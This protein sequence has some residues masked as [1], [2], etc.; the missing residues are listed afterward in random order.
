MSDNEGGTLEEGDYPTSD[1]SEDE[2]AS[3]EEEEV[4]EEEASSEED[5]ASEED[6]S[7]HDNIVNLLGKEDEKVKT[8]TYGMTRGI[9]S[10]F[11]YAG[12]LKVR[13]E[14]L[15]DQLRRG[16]K[17]DIPGY[18]GKMDVKEIAKFEI[19]NGLFE[20]NVEKEL[21]NGKYE[22]VSSKNLE[23][24]PRY[25]PEIKHPKFTQGV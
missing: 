3:S 10:P 1:V 21:P 7:T 2:E 18:K 19:V 13:I 16:G 9:L 23:I 24:D 14:Q 17:I 22:L 11:E 25:I 15:N 5:E 6:T 12:A 8:R 20:F 4:S